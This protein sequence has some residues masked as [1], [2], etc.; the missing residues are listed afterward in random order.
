MSRQAA[1]QPTS[2]APTKSNARR[3]VIVISLMILVTVAA[4]AGYLLLGQGG[5]GSPRYQISDSN[6]YFTVTWDRL[7]GPEGLTLNNPDA[8]AALAIAITYSQSSPVTLFTLQAIKGFSFCT[9]ASC[10][11]PTVSICS[12]V[13]SCGYATQN[14]KQLFALKTSSDGPYVVEVTL[15]LSNGVTTSLYAQPTACFTACS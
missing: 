1:Q 12:S 2:V 9:S 11:I 14:E 8:N 15:T 10:D 13:S 6:Q 7:G 5:T 3:N 4:I